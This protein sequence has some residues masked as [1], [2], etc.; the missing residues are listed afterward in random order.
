MYPG[1]TQSG[2][3]AT[4]D[5]TALCRWGVRSRIDRR[6]PSC[7]CGVHRVAFVVTGAAARASGARHESL[8]PFFG[9]VAEAHRRPGLAPEQVNA[10]RQA[11]A[12]SEK[13][14]YRGFV[15]LHNR[16]DCLGCGYCAIGCTYDRKGDML[17]TYVPA[18]SRAGALIVPDCQVTQVV[19]QKG[20]A[21][22]VAASSALADGQP[23][24]LKVKAKVVVLAAG[25]INSPR[26]WRQSS[27]PDPATPSAATCGCSR[28]SS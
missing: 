23:Y 5:Y 7:L 1:L 17:T 10:Q 18:A 13:L 16:I 24:A 25:A 28:R 6:E 9:K 4:A 26:I 27:L 14:G 12:G 21:A 20:R 15:P 3:K 22:G 19:T 8:H 11:P 2:T